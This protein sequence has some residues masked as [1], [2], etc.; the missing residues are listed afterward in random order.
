MLS[1]QHSK[2]VAFELWLPDRE[3]QHSLGMELHFIEL[4]LVSISGELVKYNCV[5]LYKA[6]LG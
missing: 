4:G 1:E 5:I 2:A 6:V 3:T